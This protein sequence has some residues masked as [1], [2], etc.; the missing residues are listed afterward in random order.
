MLTKLKALRA[1]VADYLWVAQAYLR[2]K[3]LKQETYRPKRVVSVL[4]DEPAIS[5]FQ[6]P[7]TVS[8]RRMLMLM[9]WWDMRPLKLAEL[10][11]FRKPRTNWLDDD[12]SGNSRFI[13][14]R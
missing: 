2:G 14:T 9:D 4:I 6:L 10:L 11:A 1:F 13:F 5:F 3:V 12:W 8:I 7:A